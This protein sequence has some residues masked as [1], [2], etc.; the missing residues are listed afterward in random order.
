MDFLGV[1]I[2]AWLITRG[3]FED[4][5]YAIRGKPSPRQQYR[6]QHGPGAMGRIGRAAAD[7]VVDRIQNPRGP[8]PVRRYVR[9]LLDDAVDSAL[10]HRREQ[11]ERKRA[12]TTGAVPPRRSGRWWQ[13]RPAYATTSPRHPGQQRPG[14]DSLRDPSF[15]DTHD[16]PPD[17]VDGE[18]VDGDEQEIDD[19]HRQVSGRGQE[20]TVELPPEARPRAC[21]RCGGPMRATDLVQPMEG[22]GRAR[23]Y[24]ECRRCRHEEA[25]E[26]KLSDDDYQ[27]LFGHALGELPAWLAR[28]RPGDRLHTVQD[29]DGKRRTGVVLLKQPDEPGQQP[30]LLVRWDD[31]QVEPLEDAWTAL[32]PEDGS[33]RVEPGEVFT[34]GGVKI[35]AEAT[36][37]C[38]C[39]ENGWMR[40][41]RDRTRFDPRD[42]SA[43]VDVTCD[44][45]RVESQHVWKLPEQDYELL[46]G[47]AL[48]EDPRERYPHGAR[49]FSKH[50]GLGTVHLH[51]GGPD[52][53]PVHEVRWDNPDQP[54]SDMAAVFDGLM[55]VDAEAVIS[56][57]PS[58]VAED[59]TTFDGSQAD[60]QELT[61]F[62][63]T[64]AANPEPQ[65]NAQGQEGVAPAVDEPTPTNQEFTKSAATT[66]LMGVLMSA[67][68]AAEGG[69][70]AYLSYTEKSAE[71]AAAIPSS[72]EVT[73][74]NLKSD[75]FGP[76]ITG[77]LEQC[78][79]LAN[80]MAS[81]FRQAHEELKRTLVVSEA[82]SATPDAG[83]KEAMTAL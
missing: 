67:A 18:V 7:R 29:P 40:P 37:S 28:I 1:L 49:V 74:A 43:R 53:K 41:L 11:R 66:K 58:P 60:S 55:A 56:S 75:R 34:S 23:S 3:L 16:V 69:L 83:S 32:A 79:E 51:E 33:D 14:F 9:G 19:L 54:P 10:E 59:T 24:L 57:D 27:Q 38:M 21:P 30:R 25:V 22:N 73:V 31:G 68:T 64:S 47:H 15:Y 4:A 63:E 44:T 65:T 20:I 62:P 13:F 5:A 42:G 46:F 2:V 48:G 81:L 8:G 17:T 76:A 70:A 45:C 36:R 50:L 35:P 72:L 6:M 77:P 12:A 78:G 39:C 26:W 61:E 71:A 80:Q 82:Y 52:G